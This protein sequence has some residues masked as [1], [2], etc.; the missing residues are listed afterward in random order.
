MPSRRFVTDARHEAAEK[1]IDAST[2]LFSSLITSCEG[3]GA[4]MKLAKQI[5][6]HNG[7]DL[8]RLLCKKYDHVDRN[9]GLFMLEQLLSPSLGGG[10]DEI[11]DQIL[12]WEQSR[13]EY[14]RTAEQPF[15]DSMKTAL[16]LRNASNKL[17]TLLQLAM[18]TSKTTSWGGVKI[19]VDSWCGSNRQ[20]KSMEVDALAKDRHKGKG[21]GKKGKGK[22]KG[23][24]GKGNHKNN[25]N[26]NNSSG[27]GEYK[28]KVDGNCSRC[29][30]YG[31]KAVDCYKRQ[32]GVAAVEQ[33]S[34]SSGSGAPPAASQQPGGSDSGSAN[35]HIKALFSIPGSRDDS[36]SCA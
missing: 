30:K 19:L 34:A 35:K 22:G 13:F 17:R 8:W 12:T 26:N 9:C 36:Q 24:K 28:P 32:N 3:S 20:H 4:T 10:P 18:A 7:F 1:E 16:L 29:G 27:K 11:Q 15:Q 2:F 33:T 5:I 21:N 31:H 14:D 6:A 23:D 25:N